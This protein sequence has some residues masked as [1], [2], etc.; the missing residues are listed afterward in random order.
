MKELRDFERK[1]DSLTR[2][3][4]ERR[5]EHSTDSVRWVWYE[6]RIQSIDSQICLVI[7]VEFELYISDDPTASYIENRSYGFNGVSLKVIDLQTERRDGISYEEDTE[8]PGEIGGWR[9]SIE[10][11]EQLK[12]FVGMLGD[13]L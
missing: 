11:L 10:T 9:L 1:P 3:G 13:K 8:S 2:Y 7:Q 4:F 12:L 5:E 6:K